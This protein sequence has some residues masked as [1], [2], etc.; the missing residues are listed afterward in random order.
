M[1]HT[2]YN[3]PINFSFASS[4]ERYRH[5]KLELNGDEAIIKLGIDPEAN[6]RGDTPLKLN[7]YELAVDIELADCLNHLRFCYPHI[8]VCSI[9][10]AHT[11]IFSAGANIYML[12]KSSHAFKVNFC[13]YTNETSLYIEQASRY[14]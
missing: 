3:D 1:S 6:L 8:S 2:V 11:H 7:S 10:T 12:K 9:T 13:K 4:P 5:L 14:S